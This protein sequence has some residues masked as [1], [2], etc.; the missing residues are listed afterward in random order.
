MKRRTGLKLATAFAALAMGATAARAGDGEDRR[1]GAQDR[2]LAG[3]AA[4][5]HWPN[6]QLWVHRSTPR[7]AQR[8][9]HDDADR[10]HRIR[11]PDQPRR[12][13]Q[14]A[15]QRLATRTAPTSSCRPT[16]PGCPGRRADLRALR[17]S[18]DR[19][20]RPSPTSSRN[21]R[22][23]PEHVLHARHHRALAQDAVKI[24]TDMRESGTSATRH[25]H[26][27]RGR[28]LRDRAGR[29]SAPALPRPGSRS[30]MKPPTRS[31]RRTS[32][33]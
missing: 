12:D 13:D 10:A 32:R 11:R 25:R 23:V 17:L 4:V 18:D 24:L 26:G 7:R 9:G 28:R 33:R 15:V 6:V 5:T 14:A 22:A 16:A 19:G 29:P 1:G 31:A 21:C 27:Q 3:G 8:R 20:R 30:S 2:G